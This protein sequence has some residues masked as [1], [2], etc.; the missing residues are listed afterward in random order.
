MKQ[1]LSNDRNRK[2]EDED[3]SYSAQRPNQLGKRLCDP[4]K[5]KKQFDNIK[6]ITYI[7]ELLQWCIKTDKYQV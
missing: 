5:G 1:N 7:S 6:S 3:A 4:R 2:R